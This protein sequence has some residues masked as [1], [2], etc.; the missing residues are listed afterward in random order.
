M[1]WG[2]YSK[3]PGG[4]YTVAS[5]DNKLKEVAK[6]RHQAGLLAHKSDENDALTKIF[7]QQP[8]THIRLTKPEKEAI[9][10]LWKRIAKAEPKPSGPSVFSKL[11]EKVTS[12]AKSTSRLSAPDVSAPDFLSEMDVDIVGKKPAK[13]KQERPTYIKKPVGTPT[14]QQQATQDKMRKQLGHANAAMNKEE[15]KGFAGPEKYGPKLDENRIAQKL[16]EAKAE[17]KERLKKA[18]FPSE[19]IEGLSNF[20]VG[21]SEHGNL[22]S[23]EFWGPRTQ[24]EDEHFAQKITFTIGNESFT[25]EVFG[26]LD[27]HGGKEVATEVKKHFA[28]KLREELQKSTQPPN[29]PII[30]NAMTKVLVQM[31]Q[32]YTEKFGGFSGGGPGTCANIAFVFNQKAYVANIGDSRSIKIGSGGEVTAASLD[33]KPEGLKPSIEKHGGG[34]IMGRVGGKIA[35]ARDI[36]LQDI[37]GLI[38]QPKITSLPLQVGDYLVIGCDGLWDVTSS[39]EVGEVVKNLSEQGYTPEKIAQTLTMLARANRSTDNITV[40]VIRVGTSK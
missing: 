40:M 39:K 8:G 10:K 34:V 2:D 23:D 12:A 9:G 15:R 37:P 26:V 20:D 1:S 19:R 11:K 32:E 5:V 4:L 38:A 33:Q 25:A 31:G 3:I 6:S 30:A 21:V 7:Q 16:W 17:Q 28:E 13:P 18:Y 35:A 27:G 24:M 22:T 29:D 36:G 14:E